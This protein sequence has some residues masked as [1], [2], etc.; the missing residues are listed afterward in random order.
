MTVGQR[1]PTWT[2]YL[3]S[4]ASGAGKQNCDGKIRGIKEKEESNIHTPHTHVFSMTARIDSQLNQ[5]PQLP[6]LFA[7]DSMIFSRKLNFCSHFR[8]FLGGI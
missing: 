1:G 5:K 2:P 8:Q 4:N 3:T 6:Q 7:E